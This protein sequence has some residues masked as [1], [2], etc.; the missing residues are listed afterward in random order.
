MERKIYIDAFEKLTKWAL[1]EGFKS[2]TIGYDNVSHATWKDKTLNT[3]SNIKI[4][5]GY[6]SEH[7][8][9]LL[10]HELG[11]HQLRKD[12]D[13]FT[14]NFPILAEAEVHHLKKKENHLKRRKVY[15]MYSMEEEFRAWD[16]GL[17]L[18]YA[19]DIPVDLAKWN[20]LK[21]TCLLLYFKFYKDK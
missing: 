2:V 9:Y 7:R 5:Q 8:V 17:H 21:T 1:K 12:W 10:L 16:E 13:W 20:A 11:H 3:P 6:D 4:E 18:A 19:M 14:E 15:H